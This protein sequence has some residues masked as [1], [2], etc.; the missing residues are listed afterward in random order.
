[1]LAIVV[2]VPVVGDQISAARI[3]LPVLKADRSVPP[4]VTSALPSGSIVRLRKDRGNAIDPVGCHAGNGRVMS[5]VNAVACARP[6]LPLSA[7]VPAFRN[8]PGWYW[9]AEPPSITRL[10]TTV[11]C[12]VETFR[13]EV[14]DATSELPIH[15]TR[16]SGSTNMNGYSGT[17]LVAAV[18][19]VQVSAVGS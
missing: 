7:A 16:P 6:V 15:A 17:A 3:A 14:L 4:P 12:S 5:S 18:S 19:V 13:T 10:S 9:T 8:L 1:M 2:H 11:H